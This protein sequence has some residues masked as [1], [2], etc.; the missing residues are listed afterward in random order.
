V[1]L[2]F[3]RQG[4]PFGFFHDGGTDV[5][6]AAEL[7]ESVAWQPGA[8]VDIIAGQSELADNL[9][10]LME[11]LDLPGCWQQA[12]ASAAQGR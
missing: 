9:P 8:S 4:N 1:A 5:V 6:Q 11:S 7:S 12:V 10:D 3:F 2:I